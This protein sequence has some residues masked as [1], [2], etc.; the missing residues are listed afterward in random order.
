MF[1]KTSVNFW[2]HGIISQKIVFISRDWVSLLI[3]PYFSIQEPLNGDF[4]HHKSHF[5][6]PRVE[7]EAL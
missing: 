1:Y 7:C 5:K 6:T 2:L 4:I 3:H